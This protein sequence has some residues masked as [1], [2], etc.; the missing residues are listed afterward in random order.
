MDAS[1]VYWYLKNHKLFEVLSNEEIKQLQIISNYKQIRKN[2]LLFFSGEENKRLYIVKEGILKICHQDEQ[3][4]EI[5]TELLSDHD[6]FG[7]LYFSPLYVSAP[8]QY[9]KALSEEV[10]ICTFEAKHLLH[11]LQQNPALMLRY[12]GYMGEKFV[13]MQEKYSNLIFKTV[14]ERVIDFFRKY[15]EHHGQ[16]R[17]DGSVEVELVLTQ[18]EIADY[19]AASRQSIVAIIGQLEQEEMIVFKGRK[20][21]LVPK[22]ERLL[23]AK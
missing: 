23:H 9:A 15:I 4:E 6:I 13:M 22:P 18:Q 19:V 1:M 12:S 11:L 20:K 3:G 21:L 14:R 10:K 8:G 16:Q 17:S 7:Y 5:I 2:E